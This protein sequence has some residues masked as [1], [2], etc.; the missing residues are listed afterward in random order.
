MIPPRPDKDIPADRTVTPFPHWW[1]RS[2][3]KFSALDLRDRWWRLLDVLEAKKGLRWALYCLAGLVVG[4]AALWHWGSPWWYK[5]TALSVT[6]QWIDAGR[7]DNAA[8]SL[9]R[10]VN[11]APE[12]AETWQLAAE[13]ARLRGRKAEAVEHARHAAMLDAENP[14][15][16]I[17]WAVEA[18]RAEMPEV[19]KEA[20]GKLTSAQLSQ[21]P[22]AQRILGEIARREMRLTNAQNHFENAL[23]IDGSVAI[24]EVPLGLI[25]LNATDPAERLRGMNFLAKWTTDK[26]WGV[27]ALRTLLAD[28]QS[29]ND[30]S[31]MLKWAMA[32]QAHPGCTLADMPNCLLALAQSDEARFAEAAVLLE[33]NHA[34][35]PEAAAQLIGWLNQIGRSAE[36]AR[37][38]KTLPPA[39]LEIPPVAVVGAEAL[40]TIADW[41]GLRDLVTAKNWGSDVEFLRWMYAMEAARALGDETTAKEFW[42]TIYSHAQLNGVHALFAGSTLFSWG[43]TEQAEA[44]WW[45]AAEQEGQNAIEAFGT[46]ARFYQTRR[47]AEGQ[48]RVFRR[49]HSLRP[50]D[51]DI[52]NNFAFFAAL[53]KHEERLTEKIARDN[54][55]QYPANRTYLGTLAFVLVGQNRAEEAL[56]LLKPAMNE[57][58]MNPSLTFAYGLALAGTGQKAQ[59]K[60]LLEH[61]ELSALTTRAEEVIKIATTD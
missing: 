17:T 52:A 57:A 50:K 35:T 31:A 3:R 42:Q 21:S 7:L 37:W 19:A 20:L 58:K 11:L 1:Q 9:Q 34:V 8:V 12:R 33:K 15:R 54:L 23:R 56:K 16:T 26:D 44:L 60:K 55:A 18:V 4:F 29:K 27:V 32:L 14:D 30:H 48:Y 24:D 2:W 61:I 49:L 6:R 36:A 41:P 45:R 53:T 59:A 10:A 5:R 47:D 43:R 40:R 13:L 51:P 39:G 25:L 22:H 28:A 46:L 38:L